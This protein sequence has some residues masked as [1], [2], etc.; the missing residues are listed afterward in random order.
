M[1]NSA[2]RIK[3]RKA[4]KNG[5]NIDEDEDEPVIKDMKGY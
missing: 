4:I 2:S 1:T 3:R 5:Y